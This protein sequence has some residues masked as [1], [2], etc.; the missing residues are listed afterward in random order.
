MAAFTFGSGAPTR[1][2]GSLR[3]TYV[4]FFWSN[5]A[6]NK[7]RAPGPPALDRRA[8]AGR[9]ARTLLENDQRESTDALLRWLPSPPRD[10]A[11]IARGTPRA[12]GAIFPLGGWDRLFFR[13]L[14]RNSESLR[15][16]H[17]EPSHRTVRNDKFRSVASTVNDI[18]VLFLIDGHDHWRTI[19]VG[20]CCSSISL[21]SITPPFSP[22][23]TK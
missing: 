17:M 15:G 16:P 20:H 1:T 8:Q 14:S 19:A 3:K 12:P 11:E 4:K 13:P 9:H 5:A 7:T 22:A 23:P 21:R 18:S 6:S 2:A 10:C